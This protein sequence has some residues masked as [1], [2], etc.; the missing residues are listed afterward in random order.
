MS[1]QD[2]SRANKTKTQN[3][4]KLDRDLL[5]IEGFDALSAEYQTATDEMPPSHLDKQILAAAHREI[6]H[7]NPRKPYKISWWR[8]LSLPLYAAATVTFA[9]IG[10]R[11]YWDNAP[12]RTP[13]K[14]ES[15]TTS[16]DVS[17]Q[18]EPVAKTKKRVVKPL[19]QPTSIMAPPEYS[20]ESDKTSEYRQRSLDAAVEQQ[21]VMNELLSQ[22]VNDRRI[23]QE[24][25]EEI[26]SVDTIE[27][28]ESEAGEKKYPD[29]EKW[30]EEIIE[31]FKTCDY[32][33]AEEELKRFKQVYP[34]YP[35]D[36]K[37]DT[38]SR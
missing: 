36:E 25:T 10:T 28:R 34:D 15:G 27:S 26:V 13:I 19:P 29:K 23:K 7:P 4:D 21:K 5:D 38:F 11:W 12:A 35:I 31:L 14:E 3:L 9:T 16:F 2:K 33:R 37:I 22:K 20:T 1:N 24:T 18:S 8:R 17:V 6:T 30:V 32:H